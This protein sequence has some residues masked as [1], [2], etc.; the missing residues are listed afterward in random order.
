[1]ARREALEKL[2][3]D[4]KGAIPC[5]WKQESCCEAP[6]QKP[7]SAAAR[8]AGPRQARGVRRRRRR[9]LAGAATKGKGVVHPL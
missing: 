8:C 7:G 4:V 1:M 6:L 2:T 9:R 5:Q 3:Q